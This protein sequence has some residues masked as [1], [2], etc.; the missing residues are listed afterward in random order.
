L[1]YWFRAPDGSVDGAAVEKNQVTDW[2]LE[3]RLRVRQLRTPPAAPS[4][5]GFSKNEAQSPGVP[6]LRFPLWHVCP[7]CRRLRKTE[8]RSAEPF[9]C[10]ECQS[11]KKRKRPRVMVQVPLVAAC[12]RGH[13]H[14]FPWREWLSS[15]TCQEPDLRLRQSGGTGLGNYR[16]SCARCKKSRPLGRALEEGVLGKCSGGRPWLLDGDDEGC[17]ENLKGALRNSANLYF[18]CVTTSVFLPRGDSSVPKGLK[19]LL[20][21]PSI[22]AVLNVLG[23]RPAEEKAK[24]ISELSPDVTARYSIDQWLQAIKSID[25][26]SA[27]GSAV[28]SENDY[29]AMEYERLQGEVSDLKLRVRQVAIDAYRFVEEGLIGS[30]ALVDDLV[31]TKALTGFTR[32]LPPGEAQQADARMLWKKRPAQTWMPAVQVRGEGIFVALS[33]AAVREW[34]RRQAVVKRTAQVIDEATGSRFINMD[35]AAISSRYILLHTFAHVL[36][37]RMV[38]EAGYSAA[39]LSER[40]YARVP[41][42]GAGPMAGVLIYTASGDSEGSLGGLVRLGEPGTLERLIADAIEGARWCSS[43]PICMELGGAE[44]QGPDGLNLAACHSCT[45]MPET[46]CEGFNVLLDRALLVGSFSE[47]EVGFF[48]VSSKS[49]ITAAS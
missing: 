12:T 21:L 22:R 46:A 9:L 24:K 27:V 35:R 15:C 28:S 34:E 26:D 13:L 20:E 17:Q 5:R 30:V 3:S 32:L 19:E 14:E 44:R 36:M 10:Y 45:H 39:S 40:V 25:A 29:R 2:R 18:P 37:N 41:I 43:D 6:F 8:N 16:V 33:E 23:D 11:E 49:P 38:F 4:K 31:V 42:D 47:P 48:N 1:D 7:S